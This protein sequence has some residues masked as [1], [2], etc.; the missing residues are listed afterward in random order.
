V[1]EEMEQR[2]AVQKEEKVER[3]LEVYY[4][5]NTQLLQEMFTL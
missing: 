5:K 4:F 2:E 1:E 3:G